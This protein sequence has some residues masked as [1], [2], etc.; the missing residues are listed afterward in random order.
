M[1]KLKAFLDVAFSYDIFH[2]HFGNSLLPRN[3]DLPILKSLHK[4]MVMNYWG[5]DARAESLAIRRDKYFALTG[6]SGES[7]HKIRKRLRE[8]SRY[9]DT[10]VVANRALLEYVHDYFGSVEIVP[11][12][13]C[14]SDIDPVYP[15]ESKEV[16][17]VV[18]APSSRDIKG[19]NY[20][21]EVVQDLRKTRSFEFILVQGLSHGEAMQIYRRA[22]IV[23][24]QVLLEWYG[25]FAIEAMALGKPVLSHAREDILPDLQG[26][27]I[28]NTNPDRLRSDLD[29]L[30]SDATLR[31]ELGIKGRQYVER[32]H[33]CRVVA[34][35]LVTLYK[36]L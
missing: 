29:S 6:A 32:V 4:R 22:D 9:I 5:S 26:L 27:P 3:K 28:V 12:A 23:I 10:A 13:I 7:D 2:F 33:D 34:S 1:R 24:D 25:M 18:H 15:S 30:T 17:V 16:P 36:K 14:L 8:N 21:L 35:Q 19:T 11:V 31:R 20:V